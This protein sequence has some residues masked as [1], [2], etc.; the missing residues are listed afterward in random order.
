MGRTMSQE[1]KDKIA[2]SRAAKKATGEKT[3]KVSLED[4]IAQLQAQA[5]AGDEAIAASMPTLDVYK[6]RM[7]EAAATAKTMKRRLRKLVNAL[8]SEE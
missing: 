8:S 4:K 3:T 6:T 5:D 7:E 2:A 1:T